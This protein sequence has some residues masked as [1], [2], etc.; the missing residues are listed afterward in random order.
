M[1]RVADGFAVSPF[2][3]AFAFAEA[4]TSPRGFNDIASAAYFNF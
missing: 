2:A 3:F 1:R 4:M